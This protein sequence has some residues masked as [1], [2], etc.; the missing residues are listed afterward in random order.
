MEDKKDYKKSYFIVAWTV[1]GIGFVYGGLCLWPDC[2][3]TA[4]CPGENN[5]GTIRIALLVM[6]AGLVFLNLHFVTKRIHRTDK[7]IDLQQKQLQEYQ[8]TNFRDV[9]GQGVEMLYSDN[10]NKQV[11]GV[12]HF[13]SF[14]EENKENKDRLKE[15][16]RPLCSFVREIKK[17]EEEKLIE[18][19]RDKFGKVPLR[20]HT[21]SPLEIRQ[22]KEKILKIIG[23]KDMALAELETIN[24]A[25]A[26]L[27]GI[28]LVGVDL[29]GAD[30]S[31]AHL[32]GVLLQA[33]NLEGVNL[34]GA[35]LEQVC[36]ASCPL[37]AN[38]SISPDLLKAA[39]LA[40]ADLRG[41]YLNNT[42]LWGVNLR[43]ATFKPLL[44]DMAPIMGANLLDVK[45][46][47]PFDL[48][49]TIDMRY[50][51][52]REGNK[53]FLPLQMNKT[54]AIRMNKTD[55]IW[56]REDKGKYS[57]VWRDTDLDKLLKS[58]PSISKSELIEKLEQKVKGM[59]DGK[60][61]WEFLLEGPHGFLPDFRGPT[62]K[63][64]TKQ[65]KEC[66]IIQGVIRRL[67]EDFPD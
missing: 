31:N 25:G 47:E 51:L 61:P 40:G 5:T 37:Q 48:K 33:A 64:K 17:E 29:S 55:A 6:G 60:L 44:L 3:P 63:E 34:Q 59:Y 14:L 20:S 49:H 8:N 35:I 9:I 11:S 52:V 30:L 16:I 1:I 23:R 28:H 65:M 62:E 32:C 50:V 41:V 27:V 36:L 46:T 66:Y 22:L 67:K 43:K 56:V 45:I 21:A 58:E 2:L 24:L 12:E 15:I 19:I 54:D 13:R 4:M 53:L 57:F 26:R 10:F 42:E 39:S 18:K 38:L 7:Q